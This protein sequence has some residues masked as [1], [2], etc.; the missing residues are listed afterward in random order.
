MYLNQVTL[1]WSWRRKEIEEESINQKF[2]EKF[3]PG[4]NEPR[5]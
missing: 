3:I 2:A 5:L 1:D 4:A